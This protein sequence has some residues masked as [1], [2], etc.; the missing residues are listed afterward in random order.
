M[1]RFNEVCVKYAD[2]IS[3]AMDRYKSCCQKLGVE[4]EALLDNFDLFKDISPMSVRGIT[5]VIEDQIKILPGFAEMHLERKRKREEDAKSH[6]P[7]CEKCGEKGILFLGSRACDNNHYELPS[8]RNGSGYMIVIPNISDSDG[9]SIRICVE[10]GWIQGFDS[11]RVK[12][13]LEHEEETYAAG[14]ESDYS[15]VDEELDEQEDDDDGE[16]QQFYEEQDE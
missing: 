8:G 2:A 10:C 4:P 9:V 11:A 16:D 3:L 5:A 1:E 6:L 13:V 7:S 15:D 14:Q 12:A